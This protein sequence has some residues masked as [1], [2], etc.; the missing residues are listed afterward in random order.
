MQLLIGPCIFAAPVVALLAIVLLP[1]WPVAIILLGLARL[2]FWPVE[3]IVSASGGTWATAWSNRM[4][5]WFAYV[6]RPWKYFDPPEVRAAGSGQREGER[7]PADA[8]GTQRS[9]E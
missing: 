5:M 9:K 4:R 7:S 1:F 6:V 3:R 8:G 2:L